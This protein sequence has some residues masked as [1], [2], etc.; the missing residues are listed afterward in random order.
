MTYLNHVDVVAKVR[1][2]LAGL[3]NLEVGQHYPA[4]SSKV[5]KKKGKEKEVANTLKRWSLSISK[6]LSVAGIKIGKCSKEASL[7]DFTLLAALSNPSF[8][9]ADLD[10]LEEC[11]LNADDP[12]LP[13]GVT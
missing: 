8:N 12:R 5:Y 3:N 11:E 4:P 2:S 10:E 9:L 1:A 7:Q 6:P 13:L